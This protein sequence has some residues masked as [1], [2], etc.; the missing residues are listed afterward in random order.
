MSAGGQDAKLFA[1][2]S[3]VPCPLRLHHPRYTPRH[4]VPCLHPHPA[5]V[6]LPMRLGPP[7]RF[8]LFLPCR[9]HVY[10]LRIRERTLTVRSYTTGQSSR[11]TSRAQQRRQEGQELHRK[12]DGPQEDRS[13]HDHEQQRHGRPFPRHRGL[14]AH[15]ELGNQED[16]GLQLPWT[17]ARADST[18]ASCIWSTMR[19]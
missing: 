4:T 19:G 12:E 8:S 5:V 9:H 7:C 16:V 3:S 2:V 14:H 1:R 15:T 10:P 11:A 17:W 18:G 13:E 6:A